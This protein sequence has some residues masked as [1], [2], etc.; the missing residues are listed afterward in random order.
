M[1]RYGQNMRFVTCHAEC[2][3]T[4]IDIIEPCVVTQLQSDLQR[5]NVSVVF[6]NSQCLYVLT[7]YTGDKIARVWCC[8][9]NPLP[10][11]LMTVL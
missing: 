1:I 11:G 5:G 4:T 7:F 9:V 10:H 3:F 2:S 6:V 8:T